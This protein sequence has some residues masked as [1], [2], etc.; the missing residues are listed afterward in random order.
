M[1]GEFPY[2]SSDEH[3]AYAKARVTAF[4]SDSEWLVIFE[5]LGYVA[6]AG[7]FWDT[8]YA[9]G[10]RVRQRMKFVEFL[11]P[12]ADDMTEWV[13][14]PL[15]F[16][17]LLYGRLR[18]FRPSQRDYDQAGIRLDTC[19]S[20]DLVL[21][22]RVQILRLLTFRLPAQ[23]LFLPE[24]RLVT[25]VGRPKMAHHLFLQLDEWQHPEKG[26]DDSPCLQSLA[27]AIAYNCPHL[28]RCPEA[29]L[30][31]HW[32]QWPNLFLR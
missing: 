28:Y 20:G 21:D 7:K 2:L 11:C 12:P 30:N 19:I 32:S 8:V 4:R 1:P 24:N 17:V 9:Y 27:H 10:N 13:P 6:E 18:R 29:A 31:T 15:D 23:E 14:D 22:R 25:I 5:V 26:L 16:T 3:M